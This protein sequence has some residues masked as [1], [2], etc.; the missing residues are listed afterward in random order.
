MVIIADTVDSHRIPTHIAQARAVERPVAQSWT[1]LIFQNCIPRT[2]LQ[3]RRKTQP[4]TRNYPY[5]K[6][7]HDLGADV[8]GLTDLLA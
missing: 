2:P 8:T 1:C 5:L 4:F 6:P 7:G 3:L